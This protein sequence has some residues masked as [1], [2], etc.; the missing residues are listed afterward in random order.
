MPRPHVLGVLSLNHLITREAPSLV[1]L[2]K[3]QSTNVRRAENKR[4]EYFK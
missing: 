4:S 1:F 2:T 3:N